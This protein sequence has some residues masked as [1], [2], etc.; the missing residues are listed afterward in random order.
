MDWNQ[1]AP[2]IS[3][4]FLVIPPGKSAEVKVAL[5]GISFGSGMM[6][7]TLKKPD[8]YR[9]ELSHDFTREK[10]IKERLHS[11]F[12]DQLIPNF[13]GIK[14]PKYRWNQ[15]LEMKKTVKVSVTVA[16]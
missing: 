8:T 3:N 11:K 9:I 15:A 1:L 12:E 10:F 7:F 16:K 14:D 5:S 6:G 4:E 13:A 2:E